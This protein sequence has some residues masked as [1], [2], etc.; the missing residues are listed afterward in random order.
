MSEPKPSPPALPSIDIGG[1]MLDGMFQGVY[2]GK[3]RHEPDLG[4]VLSRARLSG[5]MS[6]IITAG[7]LSEARNALALAETDV[8]KRGG[9]GGGGGSDGGGQFLYST[10]GV[11]PTRCNELEKGGE[12]YLSELRALAES[13]MKSG[14]VVAI[15]ECGLDYDRLKFC[16]KEVQ[17]RNFRKQF[18][19]ANQT[20][21]PMFLHNR[22]TSGDF[23]EM[24]RENRHKFTNGVVHSFTGT[25][26][27]MKQLIDLGLYIGINGCSL[28]TEENLRVMSKIP[29]EKLM[30]E[31]DAPWCEI[32]PTHA[33]YPYVKT[34]FPTT[35][36]SKKKDPNDGTCVKNRAEPCH[37]IQVIE[38]I[39]NY[40]GLEPAKVAKATLQN[41]QTVFFPSKRPS[42]TAASA[43][44]LGEISEN[45]PQN[46]KNSAAARLLWAPFAAGNAIAS[47]KKLGEGKFRENSSNSLANQLLTT[48]AKGLRGG[49]SGGKI[50]GRVISAAAKCARTGIRRKGSFQSPPWGKWNVWTKF[51]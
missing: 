24:V 47:R 27:E 4:Q 16:S 36:N 1:N 40:R 32:R 41:A 33:S 7:T 42:R 37:I 5:V 51:S 39:A 23:V 22:N 50:A 34:H 8:K 20:G 25:E 12:V 29:L 18:H 3:K 2:H 46:V 31:T 13:G 26:E 49:G 17:I 48:T 35:K 38:A 44:K 9:G 10:V 15:G 30:V 19:L 14:K 6:V 28:K 21:L 43:E 45:S 11:H